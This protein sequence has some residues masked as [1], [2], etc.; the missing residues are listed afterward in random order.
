MF[1][2]VRK[3]R[4]SLLS[5]NSFGKYALYALG[6][7]LLIV[8]GILAAL[9]IDNWNQER[10]E[11]RRE[12]FYLQGLQGEFV[13]SLAK[14]DTLI[15]VN[16]R[17]YGTA[18]KLLDLISSEGVADKEEQISNML[19][20]ALSYEIAYNPNNSL[21][22]ELI[23]S[24]RLQTLSDPK[25][26][27]HLTSWGPFVESVHQQENNLRMERER[28]SNLLRGPEGSVRTILIHGGMLPAELAGDQQAG[29]HSNLPL[30]KSRE[31]ENHILL[32]T[33]TARDTETQHYDP[34]RKK[35]ETILSLIRAGLE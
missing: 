30:L 3:I 15:A 16:R 20:E 27:M 32:F 34:L 23:N 21:L 10:Q 25:L 28:T 2:F 13:V 29:L 26:R 1:H 24:G 22:L 19:I 33:L 14:L 8:T 17:T 18:A 4:R 5:Q 9:W 35:I 12:Q 31:F 7:V 11:H 6:E